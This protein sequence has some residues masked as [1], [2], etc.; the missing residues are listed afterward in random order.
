MWQ[1]VE[2]LHDDSRALCRAVMVAIAVSA[3]LK[4]KGGGAHACFRLHG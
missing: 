2:C 1:I 3:P 4:H